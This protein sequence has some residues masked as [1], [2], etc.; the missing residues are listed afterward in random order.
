MYTYKCAN[1]NTQTKVNV[2]MKSTTMVHLFSI[3]L[4]LVT[5]I[6]MTDE[7]GG[8]VLKSFVG[9][10]PKMY[11]FLGKGI[12]KQAA[13]GVKKAI[14]KKYIDHARFKQVLFKRKNHPSRFVVMA[15]FHL[16]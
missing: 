6:Q 16:H 1:K 2:F 15:S 8:K 13:K 7:A 14:V 3:K 4:R 9:V 10:A 5:N 11:S 12:K